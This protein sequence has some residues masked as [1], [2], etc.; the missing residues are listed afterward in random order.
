ML[1]RILFTLMA[2]C[3][4]ISF[5]GCGGD[6]KAE[7]PKSDAKQATV[8]K[9]AEAASAPANGKVLVAYFSWGGTTRKVAQAI[10]QKTGGDLFE[11]KTAT[12]Y[13]TDY[14]ATIDIGKKEKADNARPKLAGTLPDMKQY[15]VILLG[16]PIWWCPAKRF[17]PLPPA[18]AAVLKE[19]WMI[20]G[21]P[22]PMPRLKTVSCSTRP[23]GSTAG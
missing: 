5:A 11:I 2:L 9:K 10:Q 12:P 1:K 13:P 7:A 15:D 20:C 16:Y 4:C 14:H 19:A 8:T 6:K 17:C 18:V 23:A 3:L 22:F 21:K